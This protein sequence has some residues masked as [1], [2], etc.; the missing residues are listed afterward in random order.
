MLRVLVLLEPSAV[1]EPLTPMVA[2]VSL[3]VRLLVP[4]LL[5]VMSRL[6]RLVVTPV[7]A[8]SVILLLPLSADIA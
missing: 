2:P 4:A 3:R 5:A 8:V 1:I 7:L 6:V